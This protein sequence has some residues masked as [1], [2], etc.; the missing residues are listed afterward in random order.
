MTGPKLQ[1]LRRGTVGE[2][3]DQITREASA[4]ADSQQIGRKACKTKLLFLPGLEFNNGTNTVA[5]KR[6]NPEKTALVDVL[7]KSGKMGKDN[8]VFS[9][10]EEFNTNRRTRNDCIVPK[11]GGNMTKTPVVVQIS[12]GIGS[13]G[14]L[15]SR[16]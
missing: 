6:L 4:G 14:Q 12:A 7:I 8:S 11:S 3:K 16:F 1:F 2:R 9:V 15:L 5:E 10:G 13:I